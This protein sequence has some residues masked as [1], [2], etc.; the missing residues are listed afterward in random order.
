MKKYIFLIFITTIIMLVAYGSFF[1]FHLVGDAYRIIDSSNDFII[2]LK[3]NEGRLLQV[4]YFTI[5]NILNISINSLHIYITLY[6]INLLIG[7]FLLVACVILTFKMIINN[8][9]ETTKPKEI[10][11]FICTL[12]IFVNV[13]VSEYML[14]IENFIM[15][16][17]LLFAVIAAYLYHKNIKFKYGWISILIVLSS[18]CYQGCA[19]IFVVLATLVLF[20]RKPN[21]KQK[22]YIKELIK[23]ILL[24]YGSLFI[25]YMVCW[26]LNSILPRIDPRIF[27]GIKQS[28]KSIVSAENISLVVGYLIIVYSI[29][30]CNFTMFKSSQIKD[31]LL[32]ILYLAL[33]SIM[34][35]EIFY[36][37]NSVGL[38]I[39]TMLNFI[40]TYPILSIYITNIQKSH[41]YWYNG[42]LA[43]IIL[44]INVLM[45]I[46][47]QLLSADSTSKNIDFVNSVVKKIEEYE[48]EN[49]I[50]I[51]N[52][53]FYYDKTLS[54]YWNTKD[55]L[56]YPYTV[57]ILYG[58]W[59][60]IYSINF[61]SGRKYNRISYSQI[62]PNIKEYF[63]N[64]DW[65]IPNVEEQIVFKDST[66]YIC[67]F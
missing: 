57:P 49:N 29:F 32:K 22:Y 38:L 13:A 66:A 27:T 20:V 35:I 36:F 41:K 25:N 43:L 37:N 56:C 23:I 18:F 46:N 14:Y 34:S 5:I 61:F 8:M 3:C 40:I 16:L 60:D 2:N 24:Y 12:L 59:C 15:V 17:G 39:R 9:K 64:N 31:N 62:E 6:R 55:I 58:Y 65:H 54:Q 42:T 52:V 47:F 44:L 51:E 63:E 19:Q 26:W 67:C 21:C 11:V 53:A 28:L 4:L 10:I 7:I 33:V 50:I 48:A 1:K 45:L 30:V